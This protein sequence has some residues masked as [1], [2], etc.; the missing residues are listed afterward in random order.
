MGAVGYYMLMIGGETVYVQPT[1]TILDTSG[2]VDT[3]AT[4]DQ[5]QLGDQLEYF[6]LEAC[7]GEMDF[8]AFVV[9]ITE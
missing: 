7:P 1:A 2:I 9:L 4:F 8:T 5:I 6:G 3:L